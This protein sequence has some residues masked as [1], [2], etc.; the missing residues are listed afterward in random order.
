MNLLRGHY[1]PAKYHIN[2]TRTV[3]VY[4]DRDIFRISIPKA[5]GLKRHTIW[6][7]ETQPEPEFKCREY[8]NIAGTYMLLTKAILYLSMDRHLI[9]GATVSVRPKNLAPR[10]WWSRKYPICI[11][12]AKGAVVSA[13]KRAH[14]DTALVI[15]QR[16]KHHTHHVHDETKSKTI[17]MK[18]IFIS[19]LSIVSC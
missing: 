14:S 4:L 1:D 19:R 13:L 12:F 7:E 3:Q 5:S 9:V 2:V 11:T 16:Q 18:L 15:S 8:Y 17:F 6:N 10:R